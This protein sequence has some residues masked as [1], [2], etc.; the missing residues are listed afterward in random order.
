MNKPTTPNA[1]KF[2]E[3]KPTLIGRVRGVD[4]YESPT[5]GDE[6]PLRAVTPDGRVK[7]TSH[8][9]LP[10]FDDAADLAAL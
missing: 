1:I 6:V 10:S 3:M 8:W 5:Q 4:L 7:V 9:E 2:M